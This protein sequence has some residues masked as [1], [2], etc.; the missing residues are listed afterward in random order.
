LPEPDPTSQK[1]T[2]ALLV[3]RFTVTGGA[4][5]YAHTMAEGLR[6]LGHRVIV[7][8]QSA[9]PELVAPYT[10]HPIPCFF[11]KPRW[12]NSLLYA[13]FC[14]RALSAHPI[15]VVYSHERTFHFD[16]LV[17]HCPCFITK[18]AGLTGGKKF[19][20][21]L[22]ALLSPRQI[23]YLWLEQQQFKAHPHRRILA[24]SPWVH[25]DISKCYP[26][27][28]KNID[29][30]PP[31]VHPAPR[32]AS[33]PGEGLSVL[34]VGTEFQ[35]KGLESAIRGFAKADLP[36]SRLRVAGGGDPAPY[37]RLC[38]ELG[39]KDRVEFLGLVRDMDALY[40]SSQVFLLP[41]LLE[42]FGMAPLE[43]MAYGLPVITSSKHYSG[44]SE[45]LSEGEALL[46]SSP[47]DADQIAQHL[48]SLRQSATWARFSSRSL[49]V[50]QRMSWWQSLHKT[51]QHLYAAIQHRTCK[52]PS[53]TA[54]VSCHPG[55]SP[56]GLSDLSP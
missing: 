45:F 33:P 40:L 8:C 55:M 1:L 38:A 47:T 3:R 28:T 35:R 17:A 41:T 43:A 51:E 14:T 42:P 34:F 29:I 54:P 20:R 23:A 25:R 24:V 5:R 13:I 44:F 11:E 52:P 37:R 16:V 48:N 26:L 39:L 6:E 50:A 2:I 53:E 22:L 4:E 9:S 30:C 7:F 32:R 27:G 36:H 12:L 49:A 15:D 21:K 46:L 56:Q 18:W 19:R 31:G 10:I